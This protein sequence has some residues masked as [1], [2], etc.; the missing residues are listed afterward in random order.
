MTG[1]SA[2]LRHHIDYT[3]WATNRLLRE[4]ATL[5]PD[6]LQRDFGTADKSILGTLIHTF[7]SERTWFHR[8]LAG[9]PRLPHELPE[10]EHWDHLLEQWREVHANWRTW[11]TPLSDSGAYAVLEYTD[12][13]GQAWQQPVWQVILHV[14]NHST[15]HRGQVSGFLR[16]LGKNPPS[17]DLITYA[18]EQGADGALS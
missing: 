8:M 3:I 16:A 15:H 12:L 18:R 5:S 10:D 2:I 6:Q 17:L 9:T 13:K 7:R 4:A 1:T 14:V 11:V